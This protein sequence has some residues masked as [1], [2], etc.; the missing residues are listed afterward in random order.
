MKIRLMNLL[1]VLSRKY[2]KNFNF[3]RIR[4]SKKKNLDNFC[5]ID[6]FLAKMGVKLKNQKKN[7]H[8]L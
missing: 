3:C 1:N 6:Y 8:K 7:Y 5:L 4:I 2:W